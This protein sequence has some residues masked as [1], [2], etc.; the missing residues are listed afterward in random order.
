MAVPQSFFRR[1]RVRGRQT[2]LGYF[3]RPSRS[4]P[5]TRASTVGNME[6]FIKS[7]YGTMTQGKTL[8]E[9]RE[10]RSK[11]KPR[12]PFGYGVGGSKEQRMYSQNRRYVV[13]ALTP[14]MLKKNDPM[15]S[16]GPMPPMYTPPREQPRGSDMANLIPAFNTHM[17]IAG[18]KKKG[19]TPRPRTRGL[20]DRY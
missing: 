2:P 20:L 3:G 15:F 8:K 9:A 1:L 6:N 18:P 4:R 12:Q 19:T 11:A 13:S 10:I 5:S 17:Y 14:S 16:E 7:T